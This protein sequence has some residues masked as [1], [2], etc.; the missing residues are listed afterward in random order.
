MPI[1]RLAVLGAGL[2][3]GS[4]ALALRRAGAVRHVVGF[5]RNRDHLEDALR[6]GIVDEAT[7]DLSRA[8]AGADVIILATP[9]G[10]MGA[11]AESLAKLDLGDA[12]LTDVGSTKASVIRAVTDAYEGRCPARFVP[13]HPIAG[14]ER[15]GPAAARANLFESRLVVLTPSDETDPKAVERIRWMWAQTGARVECIDAERHDRLLA[16]TSHLPH[17]LA[18]TLVDSLARG[19][20][21]EAVFRYAAGGFRDFTRIASSDPSMWRDIAVA[22]RV[23]LLNA[24]TVFREDLDAMIDAV[25]RSDGA[26]L[27]ER[28]GEARRARDAAMKLVEPE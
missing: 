9:V 12:I 22:N 28:F 1:G 19:A 3:A 5:G 24:L 7:T 15:S 18:F 8:V 14:D 27:D 25:A 6:L 11:I 16:A 4:A 20:D 23:A 10:A 13:G 2:I 26:W 21:A 17:V